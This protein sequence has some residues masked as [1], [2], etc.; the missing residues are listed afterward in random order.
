LVE[1]LD[2]NTKLGAFDN[3]GYLGADI[4]GVT[5]STVSLILIGD[6]QT[7]ASNLREAVANGHTEVVEPLKREIIRIRK[8]GSWW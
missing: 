6:P 5:F 7:L 3:S 4:N 8:S 2:F 1:L